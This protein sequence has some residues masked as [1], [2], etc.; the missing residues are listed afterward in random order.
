VKGGKQNL[1]A[2]VSPQLQLKPQSQSGKQS[3]AAAQRPS[4]GSGSLLQED[5]SQEKPS[6]PQSDATSQ[7]C[8]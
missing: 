1:G 2:D 3:A 5:R 7:G 8:W 4:F 6:G